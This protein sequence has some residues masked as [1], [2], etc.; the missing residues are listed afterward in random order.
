MR[1]RRGGNFSTEQADEPPVLL[2]RDVL[3]GGC[4]EARAEQAV[5]SARRSVTLDMAE[6]HVAQLEAEPLAMLAKILGQ[7]FGVVTGAFRHDDDRVALSTVVRRAQGP[8]QCFG[9]GFHL[10][11]N[12]G[13]GTTCNSRSERQIAAIAAHYLDQKSPFVG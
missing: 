1:E 3:G 11:Q 9:I 6:L 12:D 8:R 5:E 7:L 13:F 10:G 4:G 2:A